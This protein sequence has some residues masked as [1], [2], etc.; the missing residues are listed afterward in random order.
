MVS[1][2]VLLSE[3]FCFIIAHPRGGRCQAKC[4]R[5]VS[6]RAQEHMTSRDQSYFYQ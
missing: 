4:G 2:A 1:G 5:S 6:V 3:A